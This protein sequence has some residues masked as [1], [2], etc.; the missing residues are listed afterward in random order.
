MGDTLTQTINFSDAITPSNIF[1]Y[2]YTQPRQPFFWEGKFPS[3]VVSGKTFDFLQD[4]IES[5]VTMAR[6]H[7]FNAE[8]DLDWRIGAKVSQ[9]TLGYLKRERI[10]EEEAMLLLAQPGNDTALRQAITRAYNDGDAMIRAIESRVEQLRAE[11][12]TTGKLVI[13]ENGYKD[14]YDFNIPEENRIEL[15]WGADSGAKIIDDIGMICDQLENNGQDTRPAYMICSTKTINRLLCDEFIREAMF[16]VNSAILPN[17]TTLNSQFVSWGLPR[18]V[19]YNN[20]ALFANKENT[21]NEKRR[22]MP[23]D[24]VLF[25]PEG[26]LGNTVWG[27]TPEEANAFRTGQTLTKRNNIVL[28]VLGHHDTE[29]MVVKASARVFVTLAV[30]KRIAIGTIQED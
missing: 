9:A 5:E 22:L 14:A 23:E 7:A 8:T 3:V 11:V 2:S 26:P 25:I 17:A 13:D 4:E 15:K 24:E 1:D 28:Q 12:A 27:L 10:I 21:A 29:E 6:F 19:R 16:G 20:H 18:I 30:P